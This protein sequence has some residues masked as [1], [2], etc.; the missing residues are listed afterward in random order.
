MGVHRVER[1]PGNHGMAK[2]AYATLAGF[3]LATLRRVCE[4]FD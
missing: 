3:I 4:S 1:L 2:D